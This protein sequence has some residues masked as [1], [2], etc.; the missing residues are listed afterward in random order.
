[1]K[2]T[3]IKLFLTIR[4]ELKNCYFHANGEHDVQ[5]LQTHG[6]IINPATVVIR[7][8][9]FS[10]YTGKAN[11]YQDWFTT[12]TLDM[13]MIHLL[14]ST[15]LLEDLVVFNNISTPSSI[16]SLKGNSTIVIS[17]SV[18]FTNNNGQDLINFY[19]NIKYIKVKVN[20]V[21]TVNHN[22]VWSLFGTK[23]TV[24]K[25]PYPFCFSSTLAMMRVQ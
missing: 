11:P 23:P 19:D 2:P 4:L 9:T 8:T 22:N 7:N 17:G 25:Y 6:D 3:L 12:N 13:S 18:E 20:S 21:I 24:V 5:I 10:Y 15:L 16:I 14:N 1:M